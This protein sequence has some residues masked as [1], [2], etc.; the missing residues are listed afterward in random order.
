MI[1]MTTYNTHLNIVVVVVPVAAVVS[2]ERK[3]GA[4]FSPSIEGK[5]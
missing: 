5:G 4:P 2:E 1:K 3:E